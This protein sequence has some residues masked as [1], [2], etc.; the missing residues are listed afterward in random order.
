MDEQRRIDRIERH[1]GPHRRPGCP[2]CR[3][4]DCLGG[5]GFVDDCQPEPHTIPPGA[6]GPCPSCGRPSPIARWIVTHGIC[7]DTI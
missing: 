5:T 2:T 1:L 6:S 7:L 3:T 4:W